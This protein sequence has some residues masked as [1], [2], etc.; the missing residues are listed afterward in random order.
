MMKDVSIVL[1]FRSVLNAS[2]EVNCSSLSLETSRTP[3]AASARARSSSLLAWAHLSSSLSDGSS[4]F[5]IAS[6][7]DSNAAVKCPISSYTVLRLC[8]GALDGKPADRT[9]RTPGPGGTG[10][11]PA[12][13]RGRACAIAV[14]DSIPRPA[15]TIV[16]RFHSAI[17]PFEWLFTAP[18]DGWRA[19]VTGVAPPVDRWPSCGSPAGPFPPS[20]MFRFWRPGNRGLAACM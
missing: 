10:P 13:Q 6:S 1:K 7:N 12:P 17:P 16:K 19:T 9:P 3:R 5:E 18:R 20:L 15:T 11:N 8:K 14:K 2:S 4:N